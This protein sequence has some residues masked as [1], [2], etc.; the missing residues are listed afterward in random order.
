MHAKSVITSPSPQAP[1]R[2]GHGPLVITGLA[3]SGTGTIASADVSIDG[4]RNWQQARLDG[5]SL[6]KS[7]HR[8][9]LEIDW[10]GRDLYLQSRATDALGYTQPTK[11]ALRTFRGSASIY[12]MN[13]I[14][15]WHVNSS[16]EAENVEIS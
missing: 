9:Y 15:T 8:F 6:D 2:H 10:D 5:P 1:I 7:L 12:H 11:E 4:G 16:G 3:W 14:Q 13:G